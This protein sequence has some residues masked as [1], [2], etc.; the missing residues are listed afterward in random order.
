MEEKHSNNC[1]KEQTINL[2][3]LENN[4]CNQLNIRNFMNIHFVKANV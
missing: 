4:K 3:V 2:T 1:K